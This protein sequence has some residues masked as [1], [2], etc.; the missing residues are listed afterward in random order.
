MK[1]NEK[2]SLLIRHSDRDDIPQGS[3]GNEILLNEKG[4]QNAQS[5]GENLSGSKINR[6]FTS[7]VGRCIQTAEFITK[8]YGSS[9]E[10]IETTALG[11]PGL[12]ITD[13]KIAGDFFLQHGFDEMYKR[14]IQGEKI[15]GIPNIGELNHRIT[16]FIKEN[17]TQNGTT[18]FITHDMLIA[19]F[20][21]SIDKTVYSKDNWINYLTGLT[22]KNG[23][24]ER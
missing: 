14:F 7:P 1:T 21:Y 8:G 9:V 18:I 6:I 4:R 22:F 16:S 3:F 12:H 15:P 20:R 5:F 2:I 17:S 10:I 11:A 24:Y 23:I 13:E 19:F